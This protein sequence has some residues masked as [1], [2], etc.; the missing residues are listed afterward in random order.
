MNSRNGLLKLLV[1][2]MVTAALVFSTFGVASAI[3]CQRY[4]AKYHIGDQDLCRKNCLD[5]FTQMRVTD[6]YRDDFNWELDYDWHLYY[7]DIEKDLQTKKRF[8]Y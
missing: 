8:L 7:K 5:T 1:L 4:C 3:T 2:M 6:P